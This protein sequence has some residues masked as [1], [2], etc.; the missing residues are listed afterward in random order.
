MLPKQ[1][2]WISK[3]FTIIIYLKIKS[4]I[5]LKIHNVSIPVVHLTHVATEMIKS[6]QCIYNIDLISYTKKLFKSKNNP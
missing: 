3:S 5:Q 2:Y 6:L 4:Y 1:G